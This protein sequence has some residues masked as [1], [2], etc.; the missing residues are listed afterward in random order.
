MGRPLRQS[1]ADGCFPTAKPKRNQVNGPRGTH[2]RARCRPH[3]FAFGIS[4][5]SFR[6]PQCDGRNA[7]DHAGNANSTP[8]TGIWPPV[9]KRSHEQPDLF[10]RCISSQTSAGP[11]LVA[12][13]RKPSFTAGRSGWQNLTTFGD[14]AHGTAKNSSAISKSY[15]FRVIL[16]NRGG[17]ETSNRCRPH[18]C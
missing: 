16:V 7:V 2:C 4:Q 11:R 15:D 9:L 13:H 8:A 6:R 3:S 1:L 18:K 10:C 14:N 12:P 5:A 17:L